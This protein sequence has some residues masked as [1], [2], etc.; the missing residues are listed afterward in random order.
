MYVIF[1]LVYFLVFVLLVDFVFVV[2]N[3]KFFKFLKFK[4]NYVMNYDILYEGFV[5]EEYLLMEIDCKEVVSGDLNYDLYKE[6]FLVN[7][8]YL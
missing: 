4:V 2:G 5:V 7:G 8:E 1:F 6:F 3:K